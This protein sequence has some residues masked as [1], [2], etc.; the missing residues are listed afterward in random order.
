VIGTQVRRFARTVAPRG[1]GGRL[2]RCSGAE[3]ESKIMLTV[4][5]LREQDAARIAQLACMI[6]LQR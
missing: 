4:A 6:L 1:W 5:H 2:A 3:D